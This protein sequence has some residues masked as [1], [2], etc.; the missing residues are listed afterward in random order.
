MILY[1]FNYLIGIDGV[2]Y[3]HTIEVERDDVVI[4]KMKE[5]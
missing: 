5:Y 4:D 3:H 2:E 1:F